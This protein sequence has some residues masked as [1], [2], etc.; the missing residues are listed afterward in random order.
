MEFNKT[1]CFFGH[2]KIDETEDLKTN[3]FGIIENLIANEKVDNKTI[4]E[5]LTKDLQT[6][7]TDEE[8]TKIIDKYKGY[9]KEPVDSK[10]QE[11]PI[12]PNANPET[13]ERVKHLQNIK[14]VMVYLIA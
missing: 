3:L 2:R 8:L 4:A 1:C 12:P 9:S 13:L 11:L 10:V 14:R 7:T 5:N 6:C